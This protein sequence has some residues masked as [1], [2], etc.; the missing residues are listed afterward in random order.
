ML[1]AGRHE[2]AQ[3][4]ISFVF[5]QKFLL[6]LSYAAQTLHEMQASVY[7]ERGI[8]PA[9]PRT[10]RRKQFCKSRLHRADDFAASRADFVLGVYLRCNFLSDCRPILN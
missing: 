1:C 8:L 2:Q 4:K 7:G 6:F 5:R 10:F 9:L 3:L